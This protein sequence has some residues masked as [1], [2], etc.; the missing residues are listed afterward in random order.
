ML[1]EY[2]G[3][4]LGRR[5]LDLLG[6]KDGQEFELHKLRDG[7]VRVIRRVSATSVS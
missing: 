4:D 5:I 7:S 3:R 6:L 2:S 1:R